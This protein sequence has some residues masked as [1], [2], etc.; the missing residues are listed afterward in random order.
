M[1]I[2]SGISL[3]LRYT[4][5]FRNFY[6]YPPVCVGRFSVLSLH[7]V[8]NMAAILS[9]IFKKHVNYYCYSI[10]IFFFCSQICKLNSG[11]YHN[12]FK[13]LP[14]IPLCWNAK[15]PVDIRNHKSAGRKTANRWNWIWIWA[16]IP[17]G[18]SIQSNPPS[19][20]INI[21]LDSFQYFSK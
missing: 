14:A 18:N 12:P 5:S 6:F 8:R 10:S 4:T 13:V 11:L 20:F 3:T 1:K 21:Q 16:W 15:H 9:R 7:L 17:T 19:I 2:S